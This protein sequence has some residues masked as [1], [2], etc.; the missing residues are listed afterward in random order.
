MKT[1][2]MMFAAYN[3]WVNERLYD[4]AAKLSD[5]DYRACPLVTGIADSLA[6]DEPFTVTL[7]DGTNPDEF[8]TWLASQHAN[9]RSFE[10]MNMPLEEIFIRVVES[11]GTPS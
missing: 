4:A 2:Y 3:T 5:A 1:R 11:A 9:V 7:R 8:L 10:R 6:E